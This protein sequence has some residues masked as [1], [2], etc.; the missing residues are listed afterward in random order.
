MSSFKPKVVAAA[1]VKD[2]DE[3]KQLKIKSGGVKRNIK[4][5]VYARAEVGKEIQRLEKVTAT[6]PDKIQQQKAVVSE[7]EMMVPHADNRLRQSTA[8]LATFLETHGAKCSETNAE[9]VEAARASIAEANKALAEEKAEE[10]APEPAA[11]AE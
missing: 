4:D 9:E 11:K 5:L 2:T 7:A 10:A 8:E 1:P 6:D 3:V